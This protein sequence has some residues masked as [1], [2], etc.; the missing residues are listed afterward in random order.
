MRQLTLLSPAK[1]N[2]YLKVLGK[3]PDGFH[4]LKTIFERIDLCDEI[5]F[6]K[7]RS[8]RISIR[9]ENPQVPKG[10]KNLVFKAAELLQ[11]EFQVPFGVDVTIK[12]RIPVAAGLAGGSSNAAT[13][14]LGLNRLWD[15]GLSQSILVGFA[16]K[17][18]SD[19]AFFIYDTPWAL[20]TERG[21]RIRKLKI[22]VRIWHILVVPRT[23]MYSREVFTHFKLKLTK[24]NDNANILIRYFKNNNLL[25][26]RDYLKNDLETS[27][28]SIAP[29][30]NRVISRF[31]DLGVVGPRFSGSGPAVYGVVES[32]SQAVVLQAV[33]APRYRQVFVVRT[34]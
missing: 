10:R 21:D 17:L 2:L 13:T 7:N 23:K 15:L 22:S 6:R 5:F 3:R 8:G 20:G 33:L 30:L 12:K 9:C 34:Y 24:Q 26:A 25:K 31:S 18:G 28:L 1:L 19:V 29:H 32:Q 27:I 11:K 16:K 4:N 14:L